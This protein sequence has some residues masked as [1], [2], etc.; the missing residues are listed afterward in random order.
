MYCIY[1]VIFQ[2]HRQTSCVSCHG[3]T[4]T[5]SRTTRRKYLQA[6]VHTNRQVHSIS[7]HFINYSKSVEYCC[8]WFLFKNIRLK[9]WTILTPEST[10]FENSMLIF[11]PLHLAAKQQL[12]QCKIPSDGGPIT[13]RWRS[14]QSQLAIF[15]NPWSNESQW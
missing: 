6:K 5:E 4:S 10:L 3:I 8:I 7:Q 2:T 14:N 15:W 13:I 1:C 9:I 12:D 11:C